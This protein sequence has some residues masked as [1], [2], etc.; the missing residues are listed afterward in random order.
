LTRPIGS[1][2]LCNAQVGVQDLVVEAAVHGSR[3]LALEALTH[4]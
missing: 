1:A 4:A 2:A 3:Q